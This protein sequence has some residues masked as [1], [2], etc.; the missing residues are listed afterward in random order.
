MSHAFAT[1]IPPPPSAAERVNLVKRRCD[2][3]GW[4]TWVPVEDADALW[5]G[6]SECVGRAMSATRFA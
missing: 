5:V 4:N 1:G 2:T 3:C 6:C